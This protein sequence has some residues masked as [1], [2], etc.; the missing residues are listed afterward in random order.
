M[1]LEKH[2]F[3]IVVLDLKLI[4]KVVFRSNIKTLSTRIDPK[5]IK[6]NMC[7][8]WNFCRPHSHASEFDW[9]LLQHLF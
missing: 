9:R 5:S 8:N 6:K 3:Q 4:H 7:G 1:Y 2:S